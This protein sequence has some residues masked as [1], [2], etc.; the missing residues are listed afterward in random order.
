MA[1]KYNRKSKVS[2]SMT[3]KCPQLQ[4]QRTHTRAFFIFGVT[5]KAFMT[6]SYSK[7]PCC[8][9]KQNKTEDDTISRSAHNSDMLLKTMGKSRFASGITEKSI[10]ANG[11]IQILNT[12]KRICKNKYERSKKDTVSTAADGPKLL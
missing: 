7:H 1:I 11:T 4:N 8:K 3:S 10:H 2:V 6:R 12:I 5:K 9:G